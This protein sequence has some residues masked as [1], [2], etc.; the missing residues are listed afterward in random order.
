MNLHPA[1]FMSY[2]RS[3]D[4]N[5]NGRIS[6]LRKRLEGEIRVQSGDST[7][8]IFQDR[9]DI[10]W[11]QQWAQR[12]NESLDAVTFLFPV[13]TPGFFK[14]AAC[15]DELERFLEREK[16]LSRKDLILPI[17]YVDTPVLN[18]EAKRQ[19][20]ELATIIAHRQHADWR[21]LRFESLDS[22]NVGRVLAKLA[23]QVVDALE[24]PTGNSASKGELPQQTVEL[25]ATLQHADQRLNETIDFGS[26]LEE[27]ATNFKRR[28]D[29]F[30]AIDGAVPDKFLDLG[31]HIYSCCAR[32]LD[33]FLANDAHAQ[34]HRAFAQAVSMRLKRLADYDPDYLKH[35]PFP[36]YWADGTE[37]ADELIA[38]VRHA[39][40]FA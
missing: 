40:R 34:E 15:R 4:A 31:A 12:V 1:G 9:E 30:N 18:N 3:D 23:K 37:I 16:Q 14:S 11:G 36:K 19:A 38:H 29:E 27:I 25:K 32:S 22:P 26:S 17:Y 21:E 8:H 28:M 39:E 10:A 33:M 5:D 7:F 6:E 13:I 35:N 24:R 20:D 2:V